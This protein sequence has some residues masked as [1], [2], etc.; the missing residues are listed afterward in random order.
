[1]TSR[2]SRREQLNGN[3]SL[4]RQLE[5]CIRDLQQA[6][7]QARQ[8]FASASEELL[9]RR[10]SRESWSALECVAH[11]NLSGDAMLPG[12]KQAIAEAQQLP[13]MQ[14]SNYKLDFCGRLLAWTLEPPA[15]VKFKTST[16]AQPI[17]HGSSGET[18]S[19]FDR[20]QD[21]FVDLL[22]SASELSL[23]RCKMKSPFA[24]MSYN[25][26]SAF[27]IIAAHN[28]RHLWQAAKALKV[29]SPQ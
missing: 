28:R 19:E 18:L 20:R 16:I 11:L 8:L 12:I 22:R 24:N 9:S 17:A 25:A 7:S 2:Q 21:E 26:Y 10:P 27:R 5:T 3:E 14:R 15:R 1:M 4:N 13:K 23:D 6:K 29:L